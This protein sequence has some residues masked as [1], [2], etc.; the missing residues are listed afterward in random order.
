MSQVAKFTTTFKA[1]AV[2]LA[3]G[4]N[5]RT[6]CVKFNHSRTERTLLLNAQ[7]SQVGFN[8]SDKNYGP[9]LYSLDLYL[10]QY[11]LLLY[12]EKGTYMNTSK[13]KDLI[14]QEVVHRL[15]CLMPDCMHIEPATRSLA[16]TLKR[17]ADDSFNQRRPCK[18][19]VIWK[20]HKQANQ[21]GVR[22]RL[23]A[24]NI[25]YPIGQISHFLHS[26]LIDVV[27]KHGNVLKD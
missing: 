7:D 21:Q 19:N 1:D 8:N 4:I 5:E 25:G 6:V 20:L 13:P 24:S 3:A 11:H 22:S 12:D 14:L 9:V 23:I 16:N 18:F 17:W 10:K 26:Q 2:N 15:K 27:N